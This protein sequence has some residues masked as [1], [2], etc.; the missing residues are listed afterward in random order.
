MSLEYHPIMGHER[1]GLLPK[2]KRWRKIVEEIAHFSPNSGSIAQIAEETT[3]NVRTK[4]KYISSDPA[5]LAAFKYLILL[6][7]SST[8]KDPSDFLNKN[9]IHLPNGFHIF[10]LTHSLRDYVAQNENSKEYSKFAVQAMIDTIAEWS[11]RNQLQQT[12]IFDSNPNSFEIWRKAANGAGF[13]ELSRL[14]FGKFTERY[15]KYFL[16]RE[17]SSN[18]TTLSARQQFNVELEMHIDK[19]SQ[20]A[21]ETALITQSYSAGWFNNHIRGGVPTDDKIKD[22]LSFAFHKIN[23]DLI[24]EEKVEQ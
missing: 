3:K 18:I 5:V 11:K 23:S 8:Q 21:F 7:Y 14:F 13:C 16:E 10:D 2:S 4:F 22:F 15:L 24:R 1:I 9:E 6:S 19:I 12:L 17:A 20:H